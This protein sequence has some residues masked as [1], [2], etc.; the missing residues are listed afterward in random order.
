[1]RVDGVLDLET[2]DWDRFVLGAALYADGSYFE[3]R[4][5]D[6]LADEL[7][8]HGGTLWTWNGGRYDTLWLLEA[9]RARQIPA[10]LSLS[11]QRVTR[12]RFAGGLEVRD[13]CALIPFLSLARAAS[14]VGREKSEPG[15]PCSCDRHC[16]GYCSIRVGMSDARYRLVGEYLRLDCELTLAIVSRLFQLA[17]EWGL[18][19]KGTVGGTAWATLQ[20]DVGVRPAEW[21][22]VDLYKLANAGRYGGRCEVYQ[23]RA[24]AGHR[25]DMR[26]AYPGALLRTPVPIGE[27]RRLD[28]RRARLAYL[29]GTPGVYRARVVVPDMEIPPLPWKTPGGRVC[30]PVGSFAGAWTWLELQA[31]EELG[32]KVAEIRHAIVWTETERV[33]APLVERIFA[34]RKSVGEKTALGVWLKTIPNSLTGKFGQDPAGER[35]YLWPERERVRACPG[36]K[37]CA[38]RCSGRC[39]AWTPLD[40]QG[41]LWSAPVWRIP[42]CGYVHWSATL[43][44]ATRIELGAELRAGPDGAGGD[45]L[46]CDTDSCYALTRRTRRIGTELGEWAYEGPMTRWRAEAPKTYRYTAED[47]GAALKAKGLPE[48][49]EADW[50]HFA[51]GEGVRN[52]RGVMGFKSAARSGGSLFQRRSVERASHADGEWFGSRKLDRRTGRTVAQATGELLR[53]EGAR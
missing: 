27:P 1:M 52:T 43:L 40:R 7:F 22:S 13:A 25:H 32:A 34:L 29:R 26:S 28:A 3:S 51:D 44:S 20:R 45:A 38:K 4:S 36:D 9:A 53:R 41:A 15:L 12:A 47:G 50:E 2:E 31:A 10:E 37:A 6:E 33:C 39:K 16:G 8:R 35:V 42:E 48:P 17:D 46:Y 18:V 23:P 30:Y 24:A 21:P 49:S 11:G 5:P 19:L 14:I